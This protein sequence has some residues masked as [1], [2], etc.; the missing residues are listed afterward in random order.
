MNFSNPWTSQSFSLSHG[1]QGLSISYHVFEMKMKFQI[2]IIY[3][4]IYLN[5]PCFLM[6]EGMTMSCVFFS[7][8]GARKTQPVYDLSSCI[9]L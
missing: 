8:V 3:T 5:L 9:K 1:V 4:G 7:Q 6:D 2:G